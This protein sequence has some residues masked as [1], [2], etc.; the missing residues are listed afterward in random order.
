M[1]EAAAI[2]IDSQSKLNKFYPPNIT[3]AVSRESCLSGPTSY[4]EGLN[5]FIIQ[6]CSSYELKQNISKLFQNVTK[7][8][9]NHLGK[10]YVSI[11][12]F[13]NIFYEASHGIYLGFFS[14][15]ST[16]EM[17]GKCH[18]K[19]LALPTELV[20]VPALRLPCGYKAPMSLSPPS[21]RSD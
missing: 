10:C 11:I 18:E 9:Y 19:I 3:S 4:L 13:S 6:G 2:Q 8:V 1:I 16:K 15:F 12:L 7:T 14:L 17:N 5:I 20:L 21:S